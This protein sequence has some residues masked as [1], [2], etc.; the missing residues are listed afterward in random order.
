MTE[1]LSETSL[2]TTVQELKDLFG[3]P[4]VLS[5]E[6]MAAYEQISTQ[7]VQCIR[8]RDC[9]EKMCVRH[10]VDA[11]WDAVRTTRHKTLAIERK[12]RQRLEFQAA[13]IVLAAKK[14]EDH[15]QD[16]IDRREFSELPIEV[17]RQYALQSIPEDVVADVDEILGRAAEER[18]HARALE[19]GI[20]YYD[21]LDFQLGTALARRDDA[22][23]QLDRYRNGMGKQVARL[24]DEIIDAEFS[25]EKPEQAAGS[26][27]S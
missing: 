2:A 17:Q 18:D 6:S 7:M 19:E 20:G 5:T 21:R 10:I 22:L 16:K 3:A 23:Q 15:E 4:P 14:R 11:T 25:I 26:G 24:S 27:N 12:Y 8:P 13:R 9:L 1:K